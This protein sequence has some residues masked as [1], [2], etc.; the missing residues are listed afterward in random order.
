MLRKR[1][2]IAFILLANLILLA[3]DTIPHDHRQ[4]HHGE[5]KGHFCCMLDEA[6]FIPPGTLRPACLL[7]AENDQY[8]EPGT[9]PA[10]FLLTF[11]HGLLTR[12][13]SVLQ[14]PLHFFSRLRFVETYV[15]LR[16]PPLV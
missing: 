2:I 11:N 10:S 8:G 9:L 7:R 6:F 14:Y 1:I 5:E 13:V 12:D 4:H 15:P 3:H 16:A